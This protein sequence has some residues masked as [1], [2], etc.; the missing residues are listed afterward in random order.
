[1]HSD[2][3]T[4]LSEREKGT[5]TEVRDEDGQG[6]GGEAGLKLRRSVTWGTWVSRVL[7]L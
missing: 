6:D 3:R 5:E 2:S 7:A 1:M 4:G